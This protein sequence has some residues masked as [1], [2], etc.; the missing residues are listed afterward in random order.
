MIDSI[1]DCRTPE[2]GYHINVCGHCGHHEKSANY[3]YD[4]LCSTCEDKVLRAW[5]EARIKELVPVAY[6]HAVAVL[7]DGFFPVGLYNSG[8]FYELLFASSSE[9]LE[10]IGAVLDGEMGFYGVLHTSG[11]L[12]PHHPH[13][14]YVILGVVIKGDGTV[15]LFD[16]PDASLFAP[17]RLTASFRE[18]FV[19]GLKRAYAEGKLVWPDELKHLG[20]DEA[21]FERW[22]D[23]IS[24]WD[25]FIDGAVRDVESLIGYVGNRLPI[26]DE[27]LISIDHGEIVFWYR[28][29]KDGCYHRGKLSA[30]VFIQRFL[31]HIVPAGFHCKRNYGFVGNCKKHWALALICQ[32][33]GVDELEGGDCPLAHGASLCWVC[34]KGRMRRAVLVL[35][36]QRVIIINA[37]LLAKIDDSS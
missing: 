29:D 11:R 33:L 5:S 36:N 6:H 34:L 15:E 9:A 20:E 30:A 2:L 17:E 23:G 37:A 1:I 18:K 10:E 21:A 32:Q 27:Q 16:L 19:A 12:L 22:L 25:F 28:S 7:P 3:C 4:R 24:D 13:V 26:K 8:L 14:H 31:W 35:P